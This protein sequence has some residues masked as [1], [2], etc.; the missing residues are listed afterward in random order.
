L[1]LAISNV[2][3]PDQTLPTSF[4]RAVLTVQGSGPIP[5]KLKDRSGQCTHLLRV[6]ASA[7]EI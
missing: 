3:H 6:A 2:S 7:L 4:A 1:R 5:H